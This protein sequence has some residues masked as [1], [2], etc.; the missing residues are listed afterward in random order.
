MGIGGGKGGGGDQADA[1]KE[2]AQIQADAQREALDYLKETEAIPQ[3]YRED[4][5]KQLGS[6][7]G[8][9]GDTSGQQEAIDAAKN[10]PLYNA[11][12]GTQEQGEDAILRNQAATGGLRSG[13]TQSNLYGYNQQLQNK[14]LLDSYNQQVSGISSLAGLPSNANQIASL[15]QGIGTTTAQGITGAAAAE[16]QGSQQGFSNLLGLAG[17]GIAAYG[18]FSDPRLKK[19][20]KYLRSENGVKFYSWDWNEKAE[21]FLGLKGSDEGVLTNEHP[22]C[23]IKHESGYM[24]VDYSKIKEKVEANV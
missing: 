5:L 13:D 11:I 14:A 22:D 12:L 17:T 7:Y 3:Q 18:A 8:V 23:C 2:A 4:A 15:T 19:N 9:G 6:I 10:S 16:A 21:K 1:A 24:M 20:I